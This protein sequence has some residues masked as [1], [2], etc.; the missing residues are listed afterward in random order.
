MIR[1]CAFVAACIPAACFG[2]NNHPAWARDGM[3]VSSVGPAA[4]AGT[5]ILAAGGNAVDAAVA[6]GF[7]A[8]VAHPFSSG[9]GGGLFAVVHITET[10]ET[11]ALDGRE[12]APAA[13]TAEMYG[14]SAEL[15]RYGPLSVAVP[16]FVQSAFALHE[17]YGRLPWRKVIEPAIR[18]AE[19]GVVVDVWHSAL[20][21]RAARALADFPETARIQLDDGRVPAL[22]WELVQTDLAETLRRV[23]RKGAKALAVGPIATVRP[24]PTVRPTSTSLPTSTSWPTRPSCREPP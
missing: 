1:I 19:E 14:K 5:E 18:L 9:L 15:I 12:V 7:A 17:R 11:V 20:V 8:A 10:G 3:V 16:S 4:P 21:S 23:Q 13:A 2:L 24:T 22:G 6:T